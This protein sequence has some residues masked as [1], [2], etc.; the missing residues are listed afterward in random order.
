MK[1]KI[2]YILGLLIIAG[3]MVI[4]S[5]DDDYDFSKIIP[6]IAGIDGPTS[7]IAG[8][9]APSRYEV[10][11]ARTGSTYTW[12]VI[13]HS[14]K[15]EAVEGRYW[16]ADITFDQTSV[17]VPGVSVVVTETTQGGL[18]ATDTLTVDLL[19]FCPKPI[20]WFVGTWEAHEVLSTGDEKTFNIEIEAVDETS[21][22]AKAD[23]GNPP[24]LRQ[25]YEGW[26]E[27]FQ[28]GFGMDGNVL[29]HIGLSDGT[30]SLDKGTYWGQTLPGPWDYWYAGSGKWS[31]C[32]GYIEVNFEMHWDTDDFDDG[33]NR[34]CTTTLT[35]VK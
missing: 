6:G 25:V 3:L 10:Y 30:V 16:A 12:E 27:L 4:S 26:G 11:A 23:A 33:G 9:L 17:A 13:G 2:K 31:G 14:A 20:D 32:D 8:G 18:K 35:K 19:P 29:L 28:T 24:F 5:C 22:L 7:V 34:S 15:I 1:E 21:V